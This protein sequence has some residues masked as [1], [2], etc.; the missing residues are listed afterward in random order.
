MVIVYIDKCRY[1]IQEKKE[2]PVWYT[3]K[4]RFIWSAGNIVVYA[5]NH[6]KLINKN[7]GLL[8]VKT[9]GTVYSYYPSL[10]V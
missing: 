5:E 8:I 2:F 7:K 1:K 6:T 3:S 10:T 4:Y 9:D